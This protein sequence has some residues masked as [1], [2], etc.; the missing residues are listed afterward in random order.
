MTLPTAIEALVDL[1]RGQAPTRVDGPEVAE[2]KRKIREASQVW[3]GTDEDAIWNALGSL[4]KPQLAALATDPSIIDLLLDEFTE[5]EKQTLGQKLAPAR[6]HKLDR[7]ELKTIVDHPTEYPLSLLASAYARIDLLAHQD[8]QRSTGIGTIHG[9]QAGSPPPGFTGRVSDC[10][11][12]ASDALKNA[13]AAKDQAATWQQLVARVEELRPPGEPPGLQATRLM[14][15][16]HELCS[17][18][19]IFWAPDPRHPA[20]GD[21]THPEAFKTMVKSLGKYYDVPVDK[22]RY[23]IEYRRTSGGDPDLTGI[24]KLRRL[25]FA[26]FTMRG[27]KHMACIINGDVYE[28]HWDVPAT[29]LDAITST[30]LEDPNFHWLSGILSAP[31]GELDLAWRTP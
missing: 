18:E 12:Y 19:A 31:P 11:I 6:M 4:T 17:W 26:C 24:E 23:V 10:T 3:Y 22:S 1:L 30:P 16:L 9:D 14:R 20:D 5:D 25:P 29:K 8:A 21:P 7:D 27:G 28:V 2:A 15:A 13:F